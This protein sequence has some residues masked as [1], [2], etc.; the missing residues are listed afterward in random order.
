MVCECVP[1]PLNAAR[2]IACLI[3][4]SALILPTSRVLPSM[5]TWFNCSGKMLIR[6]SEKEEV[7]S[8][9]SNSKLIFGIPFWPFHVFIQLVCVQSNL[10][11]YY[12]IFI[13]IVIHLFICCCWMQFLHIYTW[14]KESIPMYLYHIIFVFI[15]H[16]WLEFIC[17]CKCVDSI[18]S[19][20][21][22][23]A[24]RAAGAGYV[25]LCYSCVCWFSLSNH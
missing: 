1:A 25:M 5:T 24:I 22:E 8:W 10:S 23:F 19:S 16:I 6:L 15:Y 13:I 20:V 7:C 11:Y 4:P 17:L 18:P 3:S 12:Q 21:W 2:C 14:Q 9:L